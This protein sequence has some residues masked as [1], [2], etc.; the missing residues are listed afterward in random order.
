MPEPHDTITSLDTVQ[1]VTTPDPRES[2][3]EAGLRYVSD[4][5]PGI[6]R[7]RS[8]RGFTYIAPDGE[9]VRDRHELDR[10]KRI[11]IPPA[12]TDVWICPNPRGHIQATGRDA[13][14][15]KQYRYHP[16]WAET[17]DDVKYERMIAFGEALPVIRERVT[18]DLALRGLPRDKAVATVVALLDDTLARVGNEEYARENESFGLTT[19]R[20][21]HVDVEGSSVRFE[22]RGKSGKE[23]RIEARNPKLAGI[24]RRYLDLPGYEL[25]Q[26]L[27]EHGQRHVIQSDDVN[28]YLHEVTS[29]DFTAKDFRTWGGTTLALR[30]LRE[31]GGFETQR[32]AQR[33]VH[34]AIVEASKR[35]GNTPAICRKS[36]VNPRIIEAYL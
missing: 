36:Y 15:R 1:P 33:N 12:W 23:H 16:R 30:H 2:A 18:H 13:K 4:R 21:D 14:V 5:M 11:G 35:L 3:R 26:Y 28:V 9:T 25:F 29:S 19:L 6:Q 22:F 8:G 17:R 31:L 20:Q 27:D 24:V 10:I 34:E 7:K 32:E